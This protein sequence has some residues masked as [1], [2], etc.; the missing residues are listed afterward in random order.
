MPIFNSRRK[1]NQHE[2]MVRAY[3]KITAQSMG[4]FV[5][6]LIVVIFAF[7]FQVSH[8][9]AATVSYS[10]K[11]Y[12]SSNTL[13]VSNSSQYYQIV[14]S[15][16]CN[17]P[18]YV[19]GIT[20]GAI[21]ISIDSNSSGPYVGA[22]V[23]YHESNGV[24]T[25]YCSVTSTRSFT[26]TQFTLV[27]ALGENSTHLVILY[28]NQYY[29]ID[30]SSSENG[31]AGGVCARM[32]SDVGQTITVD[33][34]Y[35]IPAPGN[36]E[37]P[38]VG[39]AMSCRIDSVKKLNLHAY[40]IDKKQISNYQTSF[41]LSQGSV[42]YSVTFPSSVSIDCNVLG[43]DVG[44][45]I[46]VDSNGLP[47]IGAIAYIPQ[48]SSASKC[49]ITTASIFVSPTTPIVTP[50]LPK[51]PSVT[52]APVVVPPPPSPVVITPTPT[53][54]NL[55]TTTI[56]PVMKALTLIKGVYSYKLSGKTI[57]VRPFG[58][59]YR[60]TV[61][62]RSVDFGPEGKLYVFINS[63]AYKKGQIKVFR[64]DGKLLKAYN[65]YGGFAT[66]GLNATTLVESNDLVY[67]AVGTTKAG[68][69]VKTYQVTAKGL[70]TLNSLAAST[71][72]GNILVGFQKV[73]KSGY[74]L[75]TMRKYYPSTLKVWK[76]DLKTNKF[77]EDKKINKTKIKLVG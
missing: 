42:N 17:F 2:K 45:T 58:T 39:Y 23:T 61:W 25:Q 4:V 59:D 30:I 1:T 14:F 74:G 38:N 63:G 49:T 11:A 12:T 31:F 28:N 72:Q 6:T 62:A 73:Y 16:G 51:A 60:G 35:G 21:N 68:T 15:S 26:V 57:N 76:L 19:V 5:V 22:G 56:H 40:T 75:V 46:M 10:I 9:K 18:N 52:P 64:A 41:I 3:C 48:P 54:P 43:T 27:N 37:F 66:N 24:F 33:S 67:L 69:T 44:K 55:G 8:A 53:P 32:S 36:I 65:P 20:N 77:V 47:T 7:V 70:K 71:K 29:Q 13:V 50:S 34:S